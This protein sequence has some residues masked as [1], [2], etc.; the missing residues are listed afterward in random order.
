MVGYFKKGET[1]YEPIVAWLIGIILLFI[2]ISG[3]VIINQLD[4]IL[5]QL[6]DC[7][8]KLSL[9]ADKNKS[10]DRI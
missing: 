10:N 4:K 2:I 8:Y 3:L 9:I 5:N 6:R 7:N 1:M